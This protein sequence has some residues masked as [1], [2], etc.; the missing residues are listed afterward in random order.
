MQTSSRFVTAIAP[1]GEH[2]IVC[3]N[4]Q[5]AAGDSRMLIRPFWQNEPSM[6]ADSGW[7]P[8]AVWLLRSTTP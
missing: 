1:L 5:T 2:A 8:A 4:A 3:S 6:S 7:R